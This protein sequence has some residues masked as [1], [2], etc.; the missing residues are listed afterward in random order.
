MPDLR[1]TGGSATPRDP[2][3]YRCDRM[4]ADVEALRAHLGLDRMD[5]LAHCAGANLAVLYASCH[6]SG[7]SG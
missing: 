3:S 1:G 7:S 2:A 4:V 6:P 5:L